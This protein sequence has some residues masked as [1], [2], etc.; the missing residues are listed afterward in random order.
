[1][2]RGTG[3]PH[4][5]GG[6]AKEKPR[7][8]EPGRHVHSSPTPPPA[9]PTA[10]LLR[11]PTSQ[12]YYAGHGLPLF[13][14]PN[15]ELIVYL[16][17]LIVLALATLADTVV[18]AQWVEVTGWITAAYLLSRGLAKLRT[19]P[20]GKGLADLRTR[21]AEPVIV[22]AWSRPPIICGVTSRRRGRGAA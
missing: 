22:D 4:R 13:P 12:G 21:V 17:A 6:A 14:V 20:S 19:S 2:G 11:S 10:P 3:R 7:R 16:S 18:F 8:R 5:I 1:M 9:P 15:P